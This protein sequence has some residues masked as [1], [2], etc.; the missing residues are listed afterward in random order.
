MSPKYAKMHKMQARNTLK[1]IHNKM[2]CIK[3]IRVKSRK[4]LVTL[5]LTK[6]H[7]INS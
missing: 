2:R 7:S 1:C 4:Q 6:S 5:L 3:I